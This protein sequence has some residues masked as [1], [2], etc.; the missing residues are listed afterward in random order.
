MNRVHFKGDDLSTKIHET[1]IIESTV[2]LEAGVEVGPY[3]I[4]RGNTVIKK[5]TKIWAHSVIGTEAEHKSYWH[6]Q[7]GMVEV[8]E[9]C[10]I[11]EFTTINAG[12][13]QVTVLE[14]K[15]IML[16]GS[17]VGHDAYIETGVTLSC[18]VLIGGH[19]RIFRGAN[20]GLGA[21]VHQH[22]TVGHYSMV[23]MNSTVT[24]KTS[25]DPLGKYAGSPARFIGYNTH[26]MKNFGFAEGAAG[27]FKAEI[28]AY[29]KQIAFEG[30]KNK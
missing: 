17:H 2:T 8:G 7:D 19:A 18:D 1:A 4:I 16:R 11:R 24:K 28:D 9:N 22:C 6:E 29:K 14:D 12:T 13:K 3:C 21:V 27:H 15:C 5:N 10:I 26:A 30:Q 23:G 25:I 20:L